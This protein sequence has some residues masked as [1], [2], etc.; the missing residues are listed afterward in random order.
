VTAFVDQQKVVHV[1]V[2]D[3]VA[4]D[5]DLGDGNNAP[6]PAPPAPPAT[7]ATPASVPPSNKSDLIEALK[8]LTDL[9]DRLR[10]SNPDLPKKGNYKPSS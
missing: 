7:V 3:A 5:F 8:T 6:A 2:V 9:A 10:D 1:S 4:R